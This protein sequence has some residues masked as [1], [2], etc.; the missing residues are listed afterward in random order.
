M[1][2]INEGE[3]GISAKEQKAGQLALFKKE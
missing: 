3:T 2:R 1:R